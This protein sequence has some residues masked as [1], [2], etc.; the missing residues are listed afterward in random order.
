MGD[1]DT[2][3]VLL[4][5]AYPEILFWFGRCHCRKPCITKKGCWNGSKVSIA[6]AAISGYSALNLIQIVWSL[7]VSQ[8]YFKASLVG[9]L[10]LWSLF[11]HGQTWFTWLTNKG[12]TGLPSQFGN[13]SWLTSNTQKCFESWVKWLCTKWGEDGPALGFHKFSANVWNI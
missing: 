1:N 5:P 8:A 11:Y 12:I 9:S 6:S 2:P 3:S 13:L 10:K 4:C 7:K